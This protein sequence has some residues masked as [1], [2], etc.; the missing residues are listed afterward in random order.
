LFPPF[1]L[2]LASIIAETLWKILI[3]L[4]LAAGG[5]AQK[6]DPAS[7][8]LKGRALMDAQGA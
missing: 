8:C 6:L 2:Y 1:P 5:F 4:R 7:G 3:F